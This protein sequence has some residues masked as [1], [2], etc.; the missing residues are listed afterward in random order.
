MFALRYQ[1]WQWHGDRLQG[2]L[3]VL[4]GPCWEAAGPKSF[5]VQRECPRARPPRPSRDTTSAFLTDGKPFL[6][7]LI[8][9]PKK[10]M[11]FFSCRGER[12]GEGFF[13]TVSGIPGHG[14]NLQAGH[15][16]VTTLLWVPF[17]MGPFLITQ[18]T[19]PKPGRNTQSIRH[20]G[21]T[22]PKISH[23]CFVLS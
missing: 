5:S 22:V 21:G 15:A 19:G 6:F 8:F 17:L 7:Q 1:P 14:N 2:W 20:S 18:E 4:L 9:P 13:P 11:I 10:Q 3:L 16:E 12:E 23:T